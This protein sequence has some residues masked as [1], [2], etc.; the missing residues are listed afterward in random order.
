MFFFFKKRKGKGAG[1][2]GG[3]HRPPGPHGFEKMKKKAKTGQVFV[4]WMIGGQGQRAI[5]AY[6]RDGKQLFFPNAR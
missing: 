4:D 3:G 6:R 5:A 1:R 2:A